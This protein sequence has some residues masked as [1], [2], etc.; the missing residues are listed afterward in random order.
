MF[1][2]LRFFFIYVDKFLQNVIKLLKIFQKYTL[3]KLENKNIEFFVIFSWEK[4][5]GSKFCFTFALAF[6][7]QRGNTVIPS[8]RD[9]P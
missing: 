5:V 9:D 4:F 8:E 1:F 3:K 6:G 7:K 2:L